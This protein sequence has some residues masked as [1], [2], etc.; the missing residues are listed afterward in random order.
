MAKLSN[1]T[2]RTTKAKATAKK[3]SVATKAPAA[4][5][6]VNK[7]EVAREIVRNVYASAAPGTKNIRK[8]AREAL[9]SQL[10]MKGT[11]AAT[12][13][14]HAIEHFREQEQAKA[15]D[16]AEAGKKVW[17]AV[18]TDKQGAV[19]SFGVFMT[20]KAATEFNATFHHST[21]IDGV[22]E[23]GQIVP[24]KKTKAA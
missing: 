19:T 3:A 13:V 17:S 20:K 8:M 7:R 16:K 5:N 21:V 14:S 18:K 6:D 15:L 22:A 12:Y 2:T 1:K 24:V 10:G 11:T 23:T 9:M 4:T